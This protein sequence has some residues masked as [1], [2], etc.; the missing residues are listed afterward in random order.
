MKNNINP[1]PNL[2]GNVDREKMQAITEKYNSISVL[3]DRIL[4]KNK[5]ARAS[6]ATTHTEK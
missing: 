5:K 4:I 2:F 3:T 6:V 1:Y